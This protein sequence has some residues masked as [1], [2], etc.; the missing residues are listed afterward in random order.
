MLP[1]CRRVKRAHL[2]RQ[3]D[4]T[5]ADGRTKGSVRSLRRRKTVAKTC[6][7]RIRIVKMSRGRNRIRLLRNRTSRVRHRSTPAPLRKRRSTNSSRNWGA[8][9]LAILA[10]RGIFVSAR[11]LRRFAAGAKCWPCLC[12]G[13]GPIRP[14]D[15]FPCKLIRHR[16]SVKR[17]IYGA[18]RGR[19]TCCKDA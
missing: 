14:P 5:K 10:R 7:P 4:L 18:L 11:L 12:W 9:R 8:P 1:R 19:Q 2:R 16:R 6:A 17:R 3:A 15:R 13:C